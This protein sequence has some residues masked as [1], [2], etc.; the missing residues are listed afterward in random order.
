M[1]AVGFAAPSARSM[2]TWNS[3][4]NATWWAL[5]MPCSQA[6]AKTKAATRFAPRISPR[7]ARKLRQARKKPS[8]QR[9]KG[10]TN[11]NTGMP[12]GPSEKCIRSGLD[13]GPINRKNTGLPRQDAASMRTG[14]CGAVAYDPV[15][16]A[17]A[18]KGASEIHCGSAGVKRFM[19]R[20]AAVNRGFQSNGAVAAKF[21]SICEGTASS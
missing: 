16:A 15:H 12:D 5:S 1:T 17:R 6:E 20:A 10:N 21:S 8:A 2:S 4:D 14:T 19:S 9:N 7:F 13:Q 18:S 3:L 11:G